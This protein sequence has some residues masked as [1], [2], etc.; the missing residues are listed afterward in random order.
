MCFITFDIAIETQTDV[1]VCVVLNIFSSL[2]VIQQ[3][4][5]LGLDFLNHIPAHRRTYTQPIYSVC[6]CFMWGDSEA[7]PF[8][9]SSSLSLPEL[10]LFL[11]TGSRS[12]SSA[13]DDYTNYRYSKYFTRP[14]VK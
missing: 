4:F 9:S 6:V 8:C 7:D 10:P 11:Q 13:D 14:R 2:F 1:S 5:P 3:L 12:E